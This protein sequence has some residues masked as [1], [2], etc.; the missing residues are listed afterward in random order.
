M[1]SCE[2]PLRREIPAACHYRTE[3]GRKD[4][5]AEIGGH[6]YILALSGLPVPAAEGTLVGGI[7]YLAAD[8]GDEQ[9]IEQ[10]LST[11]SSHV[12]RIIT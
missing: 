6:C 5:G 7:D 8:I 12:R 9:G 3:H 2:R 4:G 10:S 11:F 1:R